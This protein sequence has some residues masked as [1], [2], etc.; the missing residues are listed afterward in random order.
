MVSFLHQ[1]IEHSAKDKP[2]NIALQSKAESLT[3]EE[4][5]Q[6]VQLTANGLAS[7]GL[8]KGERVGIYLNKTVSAVATI[9]ATSKAGGIFVPINP[10]LKAQQVKH[11]IE[12][13]SISLL[14]TNHSRL[15]SLRSILPS[16]D[17]IT[18][19]VLV[20]DY[21]QPEIQGSIKVISW[22]ELIA[23]PNSE[24]AIASISEN[25]ATAILYTSGSTG[26]PK[27]IVLSHQNMVL[28]AASVSSYLE[29]SEQDAILALLP[30]SF[31]YGLSQLTTAFYVGARCVLFDY[32]L[33]K[34]VLKA[35]STY[36]ITGLAAVP[37]LWV[38]LAQLTWPRHTAEQ[39]RYI[40]NSGGALATSTLNQLQQCLPQVEPY[41]MYGLTEAFRSTYLDPK[42]INLRPTSIGMAIPNVE[43]LVIREDGS[44]CGAY[45]HGELV[46]LGPLVSLGYWNSPS[47]TA[48]RFKPAPFN[49]PASATSNIAVWSGDIVYK[50]DEGYLYFVNRADDM[51]KSSG[52]RISPTEIEEVLT[53]HP[54]VNQ[55]VVIGVNDPS[56]GEAIIAYINCSL[57]LEHQA[58]SQDIKQHCASILPNYM[59][60][61]K[62]II[63]NNMPISSNG[64]IDRMLLNK[65]YLRDYQ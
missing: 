2:S 3:Y 12:D 38:K 13:A 9:F 41:L 60:P 25:E 1:L 22:Q 58:V 30:L 59:Q 55:A 47:L 19:I 46:H 52:Y 7:L 14:V 50:D 45:E 26:K 8:N 24:P 29:N 31:D 16:T 36:G 20:D 53:Q 61:S 15:N 57:T 40:T 34:D 49:K 21:K 54:S 10:V 32:F 28:G 65:R 37:P 35:I 33:P 44:E 48:K 64:K 18:H 43:I 62:I 5:N 27:G 56:L 11:I 39:L 42:K 4:L 17:S 63:E 6:Q 23:L 51:I